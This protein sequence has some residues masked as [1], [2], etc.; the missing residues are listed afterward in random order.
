MSFTQEK[1]IRLPEVKSF[2]ELFPQVSVWDR[3]PDTKTPKP[4]PLAVLKSEYEKGQSLKIGRYMT[5][6]NH[7]RKSMQVEEISPLLRDHLERHMLRIND[8][9]HFK[10]IG[11][12]STGTVLILISHGQIIG[13]TWLAEVNACTV[14][15]IGKDL[16]VRGLITPEKWTEIQQLTGLAP[17]AG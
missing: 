13:T 11:W 15:F 17:V 2:W 1:T 10:C 14:P 9:T 6:D 8:E 4:P 7:G 3:T 16:P 12:S 5:M